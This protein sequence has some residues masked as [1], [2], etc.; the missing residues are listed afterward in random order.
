MAE[1]KAGPRR[2]EPTHPGRIVADALAGLRPHLSVRQAALR[3]GVTPQA[4][5]NVIE[6]KSGVTPEMALR[7][8]TFFGN[9]A[10]LWLGMQHDFDL[11]RAR[12]KM[13]TDLAKIKPA[14]DAA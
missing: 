5:A 3:I 4:L 1:F 6:A 11:W 7:L 12:Q 8:G 14:S 9:G 10:E 2:R 13:R